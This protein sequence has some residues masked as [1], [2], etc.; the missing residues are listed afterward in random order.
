MTKKLSPLRP[1]DAGA[2]DQGRTAFGN[3]RLALEGPHRLVLSGYSDAE[4][5][6]VV[7]Y[8]LPYLP[9]GHEVHRLD[10]HG[11]TV[12][13]TEGR[14]WDL[15]QSHGTMKRRGRTRWV[16]RGDLSEGRLLDMN[17]GEPIAEQVAS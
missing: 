8:L 3:V 7:R 13:D 5:T 1:S 10:R 11:P 15:H 9:Y 2:L 14:L 4:Q 16:Q 12:T 6:K 17:T